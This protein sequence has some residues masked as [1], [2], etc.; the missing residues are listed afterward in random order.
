[1]GSVNHNPSVSLPALNRL[2]FDG[3]WCNDG[4]NDALK[5]LALF[6]SPNSWQLESMILKHHF[7]A[8]YE[9]TIFTTTYFTPE[10][11]DDFNHYFLSS[12]P[13]LIEI[14]LGL[15]ALHG[16]ILP[17]LFVR[18]PVLEV[19]ELRSRSRVLLCRS[20]LCERST[21]NLSHEKAMEFVATKTQLKVILDVCPQ[22]RRLGYGVDE[23]EMD[24]DEDEEFPRLLVKLY[25]MGEE[26]DWNW[27]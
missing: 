6:Q 22:I 14:R 15:V 19:L 23:K 18:C 12:F 7:N 13:F 4:H 2:M 8:K 26:Y 20:T 25:D 9:S 21:L 10:I 16:S 1:M 24:E 17:L 27:G 3:I 5:F 11:L